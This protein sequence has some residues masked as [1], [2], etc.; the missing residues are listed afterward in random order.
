MTKAEYGCI[1]PTAWMLPGAP[2]FFYNM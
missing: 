2:I 1:N